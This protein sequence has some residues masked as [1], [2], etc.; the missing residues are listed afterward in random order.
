MHVFVVQSLMEAIKITPK[1]ELEPYNITFDVDLSGLDAQD[2]PQLEPFP[3]LLPRRVSLLPARW[4]L[5]MPT[6][7]APIAW[8]VTLT[9]TVMIV[10]GCW[11]ATAIV[12]VAVAVPAR[13]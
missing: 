13:L 10:H 8:V 7:I 5:C 3:A 11:A 9:M 12:D 2:G 1:L 4:K 6:V